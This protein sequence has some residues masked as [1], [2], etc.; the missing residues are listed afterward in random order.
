[1]VV[2]SFAIV[3]GQACP[4]GLDFGLWKY[5]GGR[6]ASRGQSAM[7][8]LVT[9]SETMTGAS[10]YCSGMRIYESIL[11]GFVAAIEAGEVLFNQQ[12]ESSKSP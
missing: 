3:S 2:A 1:M 6:D 10:T 4:P 9:L 8:I 5:A 7:R 12:I 11:I